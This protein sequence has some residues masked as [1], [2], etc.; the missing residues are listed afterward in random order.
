MSE[1]RGK[2]KGMNAKELFLQGP[3]W[4]EAG[5]GRQGGEGHSTPGASL[6]HEKGPVLTAQGPSTCLHARGLLLSVLAEEAVP[7]RGVPS[8]HMPLMV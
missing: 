4:G 5:T 7:E 6:A 2:L 1:G 8:L 3:P